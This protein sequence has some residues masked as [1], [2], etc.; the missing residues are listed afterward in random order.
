MYPHKLYIVPVGSSRNADG[1]VV[2]QEQGEVFVGNCRL[3]TQG[4]ASQMTMD[5]G[6]QVYSSAVIYVHQACCC[7][8]TGVLVSVKDSCGNELIR[9]TVINCSRTQLHARIWV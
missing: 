1:Y 7:I 2:S 3:E 6:K 8:D 4:R 9:K 5:D